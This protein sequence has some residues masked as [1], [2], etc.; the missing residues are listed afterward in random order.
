MRFKLYTLNRK[1]TPVYITQFDP[2][3]EQHDLYSTFNEKVTHGD[4]DQLTLT[5]SLAGKV[6]ND[7][8]ELVVNPYCKY[9][10]FGNKVYLDTDM[11]L[12]ELIITQ[13]APKLGSDCTIYDY[14]CQDVISYKW[15][16]TN[17]GYSYNTMERGGV[18]TLFEIAR[19]ILADCKLDT[20]WTIKQNNTHLYQNANLKTE[21]ITLQVENSNP[22]NALVEGLNALN[23]SMLV[24]YRYHEIRF[25]QKDRVLFS[26]Y[27]YRPETNLRS[28]SASYNMDELATIMHIRG[29][30][31]EKGMNIMLVPPMPTAIKN[32]LT[33][34]GATMPEKYSDFVKDDFTLLKDCFLS[35]N[36]N[37]EVEKT[38]YKK[39]RQEVQEFCTIA[40][41]VPSLGQFLYNFDFFLQNGLMSQ[42]QY[43]EVK[44]I[45]DVQMKNI[46]IELKPLLNNY[47][48]ST[49]EIQKLLID[50]ESKLEQINS[51][52][53]S[54]IN[55]GKDSKFTED[56]IKPILENIEN[57]LN[58]QF[59]NNY[60]N[61]YGNHQ[62]LQS[63]Q[64]VPEL[65]NIVD[66]I[67]TYI[68]IREEAQYYYNLYQQQYETK[69]GEKFDAIN[70]AEVTNEDYDRAQLQG[71][72]LYYKKR[73]YLALQMCGIAIDFDDF[74]N[75]GNSK[76]P[77]SNEFL[78]NPNID[79]VM[80]NSY[81][82]I[83]FNELTKIITNDNGGYGIYS[84]VNELEQQ[85]QSLW[86]ILYT[87]YSQFIYEAT[88]ENSD[89]LNSV[90]LYNQAITY[91]ENYHH[92]KSTYSVEI[93]NLDDL[94]QIGTP[95]LKINSRIRIYNEDLGLKE[96]ITYD[97]GAGTEL[98]NIS[99]T[100]NELLITGLDY[101]LRKSSVASITVERII[102]H[103]N[104]LQKLIKAIR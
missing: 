103:Q 5:F 58:T 11:G 13:I 9:L 84:L 91:F 86:S 2:L 76:Y 99:Y 57:V 40:D 49:W 7:R 60:Y 19:D 42:Q 80:V 75:K 46:N 77:L 15:T 67:K 90:S 61:I 45:F 64:W 63:N 92:P 43:N 26:G 48:I 66:Q 8:G 23:A 74:Y 96:G 3:N 30:T 20:E 102:Q 27:R 70:T 71:D 68:T 53:Y 54:I 73:Y 10:V 22:Y 47:Y 18:K 25:Y 79:A 21:K 81:Y 12:Y 4:N 82:G 59:K 41:K 50:V 31:D 52:Y 69:Y 101:E 39:E 94:E 34:P 28:L 100:T 95:N 16:R 6:P 51:I 14:T 65:Q 35:N 89:E 36:T 29:G 104:I 32:Y 85:I 24:N 72:I 38:A 55:D 97:G 88:Y 37:T 33:K 93:I 1:S 83:Y 44:N 98:N 56:D 87:N 17:I 78:D 62:K